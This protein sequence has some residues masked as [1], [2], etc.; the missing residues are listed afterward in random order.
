MIRIPTRRLRFVLFRSASQ[1]AA[2][3]TD[4]P[5]ITAQSDRLRLYYRRCGWCQPS[6]PPRTI[7]LFAPQRG[8]QRM[9]H[10]FS[11]Q[12]WRAFQLPPN[13]YR[14]LE[15]FR[16]LQNR[17][18]STATGNRSHICTAFCILVRREHTGG[19][20]PGRKNRTTRQRP[21]GLVVYDDDA[22]WTSN[23]IEFDARSE[24]ERS[25]REDGGGKVAGICV[26]GYAGDLRYT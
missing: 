4:I 3:I 15:T 18:F 17:L 12:H 22:G 19:V 14:G 26:C 6:A 5:I 2:E 11:P 21:N 10:K 1:A 7:F 20:L 24:W 25:E 16:I 13:F 9:A 8:S 23:E